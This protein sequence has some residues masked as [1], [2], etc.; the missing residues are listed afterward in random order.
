MSEILKERDSEEGRMQHDKEKRVYSVAQIQEI[1]GV[2]TP[3]AYSLIGRHLFRCVHIG[4]AIRISKRS[5]DK[6][7]DNAE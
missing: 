1:L 2:S 5:F 6:W 4:A 3:T 7:L